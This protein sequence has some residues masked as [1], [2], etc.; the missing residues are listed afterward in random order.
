MK[1][2]LLTIDSHT[3]DLGKFS[4]IFVVGGGKASGL[5]AEALETILD[6][7]I[8]EGIVNIPYGIMHRRL[9][10]VNLHMASHPI[11]DEAGVKGTRHMLDLANQADE[12]DL[13]ICL[14]SGGG[15]S[16]MPLPRNTIS[17]PD[18]KVVT[19]ALL[20]SG[21]TIAEINSVRKHISNFKGGWLAEKA[22]PATVVNLLLSDVVGDSVDSIAS[23]PSVPDP[24]TF[25]D[26]IKV[27]RK[28]TLWK[29]TPQSVRKTLLDGK[30]G[31]L[32]ET[33]KA[34]DDAFKRVHSFIVGNNYS[35]SLAAYSKLQDTG[36]N[37][38]F[39]TSY[40]EGEARHVG[41]LFASIIREITAS[42][43]PIPKPAGVVA[44]GETTVTVVGEG[45]GGRNQETVLSA[46]LDI[47]GI[48]GA[49][50][51]SISTDGIDGSTDAAGALADGRTILRSQE[52]EAEELLTNNDSYVFFSESGDLIFTGPTGTN[53]NDI[54]VIV[55]I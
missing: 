43:K 36:L 27:L 12:N 45:T 42:G 10:R 48:E 32:P 2:N 21:A 55:V 25:Q 19:N 23:G 49:V 53:V 20:R 15:S 41:R 29:K 6:G 50:M 7:W 11:P 28:Y 54:V 30:T 1:K 44:G 17:L 14:I 5:M 24:T 26:A 16:L 3:F 51:A 33:P 8:T 31:L 52:L 22:Y 35:A 38:L 39:L 9:E 13:I 4:N 47:R 34:D 37:T 46:A 18:K 40:M